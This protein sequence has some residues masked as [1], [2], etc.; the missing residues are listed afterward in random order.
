[1]I[2]SVA[3]AALVV[4]GSAFAGFS[5]AL[6]DSLYIAG[7]RRENLRAETPLEEGLPL[8]AAVHAD[9]IKGIDALY[10]IAA[11]LESGGSPELLA[12]VR[13]QVFAEPTLPSGSRSN[14]SIDPPAEVPYAA[15]QFVIRI[16][17]FVAEANDEV[18]AAISGLSNDE[19]REVIEGLPRCAVDPSLLT[20]D[21]IER[22][23][24]TWSRLREL[25]AK[26]DLRRIRQAAERL[27]AQIETEVHGGISAPF[28]GKFKFNEAGLTIVVAGQG[29]D[30]HDDRNAQLTIDFGGN[31]RYTGRHGA[32][33]GYASA[34]IDLGG[35]DTYVVPDVSLGV[36]LLGIGLG[37]DYGG[38]DRFETG[39]L[40]LGAGVAGVGQ[41][42]LLGTPGRQGLAEGPNGDDLVHSRTMAQGF[43][44]CGIGVLAR[45]GSGGHFGAQYLAQGAALTEGVGWL[46][47]SEGGDSFVASG[48]APTLE[49]DAALRARSQGFGG[50]IGSLTSEA[51]GF[52]LLSIAGPGSRTLRAGA[53]AQGCG[54]D[55]GIGMLRS[56]GGAGVFAA[57]TASQ[58]FGGN[59]GVGLLFG[60]PGPD[61]YLAPSLAQGAASESGIGLLLDAGGDDLYDVRSGPNAAAHEGGRGLLLDRDGDDRYTGE[62]GVG[63]NDLRDRSLAIR[64]DLA[65]GGAVAAP[66]ELPRFMMAGS[67]RIETAVG[68]RRTEVPPLPPSALGPARAL[69]GLE[70]IGR[71]MREASGLAPYATRAMRLQARKDLAADLGAGSRWLAAE[72]SER[73]VRPA[74]VRL[75]ADLMRESAEGRAA[76]AALAGNGN[77]RIAAAALA[78]LGEGGFVEGKAAVRA[79]L[80][81]PETA[82]DAA[83]AAARMDLGE[84]AS[85]LMLLCASAEPRVRREAACA[86]AKLG[87]PESVATAQVL[88]G[89]RDPTVRRAAAAL[90]GRVGVRDLSTLVALMNGDEFTA[91]AAMAALGGMGTPEALKILG[92]K[93]DDTR[94]WI[95]IEALRQ[96]NGRCPA[97]YRS[98][99]DA[100]RNDGDRRV[101]LAASGV[102]PGRG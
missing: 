85:E 91:R 6:D 89:D 90:I 44:L 92:E 102:D 41:F 25:M 57:G 71:A 26:V 34:V 7:L 60:S 39:S 23:L 70:G 16:A 96:L 77:P 54:L 75:L 14:V 68:A 47:A 11:E 58:G 8:A 83:R 64:L 61:A 2:A 95:K 84:A 101:R 80:A 63:T 46:V 97:E 87:G 72:A 28:T 35:D 30:V 55:G 74:E 67:T 40:A 1:M 12:L 19:K 21:F 36:G 24:P 13:T 43:G 56:S 33:I 100:C 3:A 31:D 99:I 4:Q 32:G 50:R 86:L 38:I 65:D 48:L 79:D 93:L 9:P 45:R 66:L 59:Q 42:K 49:S 69:G 94:V 5:E 76:I 52:G 51:G 53:E 82:A 62:R 73:P 37:W 18:R 27:S 78:V 17:R 29:D 10:G 98:R 15:R 88:L 20:L 81:R 22:P